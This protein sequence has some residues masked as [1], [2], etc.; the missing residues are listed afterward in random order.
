M[1]F[2]NFQLHPIIL[3]AVQQCGYTTPTPIQC[4][5][6]PKVLAGSDLIA[7]ANTGTGKTA[8][9]VLPAL[10]RLTQRRRLKKQYGKPSILILTPTRELANQVNQAIRKYGKNVRFFNAVLVGGVPYGP[11]LK[12]LSRPLDIVVAT[13][14]RLLDLMERKNIDLSNIIDEFIQIKKN[15]EY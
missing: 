3:K 4:E 1:S 6:I 13:P 12:N 9:F 11:Q 5:A 8:S 15:N 7:S 2:E 14:G 10:Q